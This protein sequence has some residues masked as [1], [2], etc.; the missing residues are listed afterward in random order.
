MFRAALGALAGATVVLLSAAGPAA[1][2]PTGAA[3]TAAAPF[4]I[5]VLPPD[6]LFDV[7]GGP[8]PLVWGTGTPG[9]EV[10]TVDARTGGVVAETTVRADGTWDAHT[11]DVFPNGFV[12]TALRAT[13]THGAAVRTADTRLAYVE[14]FPYDPAVV[15]SP[16]PGA[17]VGSRPTITGT[18][19]PGETVRVVDH[20][21][22]VVGQPVPVGADGTWRFTFPTDLA[23][24]EHHFLLQSL[25]L[26]GDTFFTTA[27]TVV[28]DGGGTVEPPATA[29]IDITSPSAHA[30]LDSGIVTYEGTGEPTARVLLTERASGIEV[31]AT[32]VRADGTWSVRAERTL[33]DGVHTIDAEQTVRE[34]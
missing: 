2:A 16:A 29:P 9:A 24:G 17:T 34:H 27:A 23:A 19:S 33:T 12:D 32:T 1:A 20:A 10:E 30:V 15:T 8:S 3:L 14:G 6:H 31:A 25:P 21:N 13:E 28:V 18:D 26:G 22:A 7:A 11:A 4:T 5:N